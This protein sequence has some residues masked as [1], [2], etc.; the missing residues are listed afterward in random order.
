MTKS[1]SYP[2]PH[3]RLPVHLGASVR[4][5]FAKSA[6]D[7]NDGLQYSTLEFAQLPSCVDFNRP[8]LLEAGDASNSVNLH[9]HHTGDGDGGVQLVGTRSDPDKGS[10][11]YLL[12]L[13]DG[14]WRLELVSEAIVGIKPVAGHDCSSA[15]PAPGIPPTTPKSTHEPYVQEVPNALEDSRHLNGIFCSQAD[16]EQES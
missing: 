7:D 10:A 2:P 11:D 9:F 3:E 8:A 13:E 14:A 16:S 4:R 5:K 12:I 6:G 15:V 1:K